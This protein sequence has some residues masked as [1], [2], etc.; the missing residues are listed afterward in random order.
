MAVGARRLV[1]KVGTSTLTAGAY[2]L[3]PERLDGLVDAVAVCKREGRDV[4]LVTSGAIVTG[5]SRLGLKA[6]P[7]AMPDRQALAAVGQA[8][9]MH[10]YDRRFAAHGMLV[11]QVL[12]TAGDF[13]HRRRYL[14]ARNTMEALLRRGVVP[15]VNENDTIATE[16]IR[17]GDNDTLSA[18]VAALVDAELLCILSDVD[19]LFTGDPRKDPAAR[20]IP[21]VERI[22]RRL[23]GI[24]AD[25]GSQTGVGGMATKLRAA[26][27]AT[28]SGVEVVIAHGGERDAVA[29]V[30]AGEDVGTRFRARPRPLRGRRRWLALRTRVRGRLWIDAGAVAAVVDRGKSLLASGITAVEG[31]FEAGDVVAILGPGGDEIARGVSTYGREDLDRIKGRRSQDAAVILGLHVIEAVHRDNMVVES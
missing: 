29:R 16:E 31:S 21:V 11:G 17:I 12:L 14:N 5:A 15:I 25:T 18:R 24:A 9:L 3:A 10:E 2:A 7:R 4:V 22:T 28:A 8:I 27:M 6:P 20:R 23:E 30:L 1:L 13:D 26:R 19:G